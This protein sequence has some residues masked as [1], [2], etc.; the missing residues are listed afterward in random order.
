MCVCMMACVFEYT[1]SVQVQL[2]YKC[3][4]H[5]VCVS[6]CESEN[7]LCVCVVCVC[8]CVFVCVCIHVCVHDRMCLCVQL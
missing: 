1:H 8:V 7:N 6:S 3:V 4:Q 5:Y 2:K